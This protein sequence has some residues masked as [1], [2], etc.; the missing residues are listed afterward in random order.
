MQI[1]L[2]SDKSHR[3]TRDYGALNEKEGYA[4]RALFVVDRRQIIRHVTINDDDLPRSVDEVL[5][6]VKT[7]RFVDKNGNVCPYAPLPTKKA[8]GEEEDYFGT[9]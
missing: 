9:T 6:V 5:R 7:C 1:P 4:Y 2:V 3:I 8:F